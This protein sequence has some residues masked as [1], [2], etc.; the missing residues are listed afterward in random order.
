MK[1]IVAN[2]SRQSVGLKWKKRKG[3]EELINFEETKTQ[4]GGDL[5]VDGKARVNT[6]P[7]LVQDIAI[8]SLPV[9]NM[10]QGM[11]DLGITLPV[12][13]IYSHSKGVVGGA[14]LT[15]SGVFA[16]L[17]TTLVQTSGAGDANTD[18]PLCAVN[19]FDDELNPVTTL[20]DAI[21]KGH[22]ELLT[23]DSG[24]TIGYDDEFHYFTKNGS[25]ITEAKIQNLTATLKQG[26]YIDSSVTVGSN[27]YVNSIGY[28]LDLKSEAKYQHTV[29][30]SGGGFE[31]CFTAPSSKN[32]VID[33]YEDLGIVFGGERIGLTGYSAALSA[34]PVLIDLHGGSES[35]D[36][37]RVYEEGGSTFANHKLSSLGAITFADDVYIPN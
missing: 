19:V 20:D 13:L 27:G 37:I 18:V 14:E 7:F 30:L 25:E 34:K 21:A 26:S 36:F 28:T 31:L 6:L 22:L 3:L 2:D 32:M 8:A 11:G 35:N 24:S 15:A 33:S 4:I 1:R 29:V 9:K 17:R 12:I 10:A 23:L 16:V 5:E